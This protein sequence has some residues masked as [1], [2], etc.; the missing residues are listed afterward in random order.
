MFD[1]E[2]DLANEVAEEV[3]GYFEET[4]FHT[5]IPRDVHVSE[6]P[7]HGQSVLDYAPR[8]R[9]A[10]AYTELVMEVLERE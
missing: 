10:W 5:M 4:V 1:P 6:A 3:R 7:S 9:A 2:L 8:A